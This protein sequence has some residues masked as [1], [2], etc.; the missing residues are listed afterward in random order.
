MRLGCGET[1]WKDAF[2]K[3]LHFARMINVGIKEQRGT[4]TKVSKGFCSVA[5]VVLVA[6]GFCCRSCCHFDEFLNQSC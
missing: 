2:G 4:K 1:T 5:A 3:K 6:F